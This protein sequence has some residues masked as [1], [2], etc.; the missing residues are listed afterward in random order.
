MNVFRSGV[1]TF[2]LQLL[3]TFVTVVSCESFTAAAKELCQ[4]QSTISQQV[5]RL[6]TRL[7]KPLFDRTTRSVV[8]TAEG[9]LLLDYA[10]AVLALAQEAYEKINSGRLTGRIKIAA[11]DDLATHRLPSLLRRFRRLHPEV[12]IEIEVGLTEIM[13]GELYA[14][15]FDLVLGKRMLGSTH[16]EAFGEDHLVWVGDL[17]E[18][19]VVDRRSLPLA[20]FPDG[21][22][23]RRAAIKALQ[24][25]NLPWEVVC[26]SPSLAAIH[27]AVQAGIAISP[28][29]KGLIG[30]LPIMNSSELPALPIIEFAVFLQAKEQVSQPA[31]IFR[32]LLCAE[33]SP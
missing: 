6:E 22:L 17:G 24:D 3:Q 5:R 8:L 21:C 2:D 33:S 29:A 13:L 16:G 26:T 1:A 7:G 11:S 14:Q 4:T 32:D 12:A 31:A 20:L 25:S 30:D 15:N 19:S 18:R 9:F 27:A 23:Y 28:L 10:R